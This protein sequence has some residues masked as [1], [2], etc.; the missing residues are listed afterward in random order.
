MS[1]APLKP[2]GQ[3]A[4]VTPQQAK[5]E[6]KTK[7]RSVMQRI[8]FQ[9]EAYGGIERLDFLDLSNKEFHDTVH[10]LWWGRQLA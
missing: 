3:A 7:A 10:T 8:Y 9:L 6:A 5:T 4:P 2:R 1:I